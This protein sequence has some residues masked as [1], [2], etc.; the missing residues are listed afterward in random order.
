MKVKI[1]ILYRF[2]SLAIIF[3]SGIHASFSGNIELIR[4]DLESDLSFITVVTNRPFNA[5]TLVDELFPN[6]IS[7][8]NK[9]T[10]LKVYSQEGKWLVQQLESIYSVQSCNS[11]LNDWLV[12]VH[13]DSQSPELSFTRGF[14]LQQEYGI[15]VIVF[16]WPS[17]DPELGGIKN[18]Q[19]SRTR[20]EKGAPGFVHFIYELDEWH[21]TNGRKTN[22]RLSLFLHSLGNYYLERAANDIRLNGNSKEI[23]DNL[24][25]NAAAIN[26]KDHSKWLSKI[27]L[28]K[29]IFVNSNRKDMTLK[30]VTLFTDFGVQLG[31]E[32]IHGFADNAIYINFGQALKNENNFGLLHGYYAGEV[33][34]RSDK[35]YNYYHTIFHGNDPDLQNSS[36]FTTNDTIP[37]FDIKF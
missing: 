33:P 12:Y 28:Q 10:Y 37:V 1:K 16:S 14:Q 31:E 9:L 20:I 22:S 18:F 8:E 11:S 25:L 2:L 30:G 19:Q 5:D 26:E 4:E 3:I 24:V 36:V 15:N 17:K 7:S 34:G 35:I 21:S 6:E 23:F 32:A 27:H 13:G 29:R